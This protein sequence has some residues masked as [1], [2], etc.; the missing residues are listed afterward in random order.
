MKLPK[1]NL[2]LPEFKWFSGLNKN[3]KI[4][5]VAVALVL[6][7]DIV[8]GIFLISNKKDSYF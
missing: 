1:L 2:K 8:A 5:A 7:A 6:I 4:I 3:Q